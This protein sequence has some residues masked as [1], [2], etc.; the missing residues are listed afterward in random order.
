MDPPVEKLPDEMTK[1]YENFDLIEK[2]NPEEKCFQKM[3]RKRTERKRYP[4]HACPS[5]EKYYECLNLDE[6]ELKKRKK[7]VSRH[8]GKTPPKTPEH[9]W[10]MG[11]PDYEEC[12]KRG[13]TDPPQPYYFNRYNKYMKG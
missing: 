12:L 10:E 9:F 1:H 3:S 5:C 8:R 11:F 4:G 7:R 6:K 13:Y 2:E